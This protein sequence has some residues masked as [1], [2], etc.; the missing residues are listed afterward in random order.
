MTGRLGKRSG[1][2]SRS[3]RTGK[4]DTVRGWRVE[5]YD[6]IG[7]EPEESSHDAET[8]LFREPECGGAGSHRSIPVEKSFGTVYFSIEL[9]AAL[10]EDL[11]F[12]RRRQPCLRESI[13]WSMRR[14][15]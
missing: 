4:G 11:I 8:S 3:H 7:L 1:N 9:V 15:I 13:T 6:R 2:A 14:P 5:E 10:W 12:P